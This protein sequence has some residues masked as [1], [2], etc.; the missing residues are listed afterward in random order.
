MYAEIWWLQMMT[1]KHGFSVK[2][3]FRWRQPN[4]VLILKIYS[5]K[6]H[7]HGFSF[8]KGFTKIWCTPNFPLPCYFIKFMET[9]LMFIK[10]YFLHSMDFT[11]LHWT[12]L[13]CTALY[14][15]E[16]HYTCLLTTVLCTGEHGSTDQLRDLPCYKPGQPSHTRQQ[17]Y[18]AD[19]VYW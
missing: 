5:E 1:T 7:D 19:I 9:Y 14:S 18:M 6:Y 10:G 2:S 12:V 17:V 8:K 11:E 4:M 13:F 3:G 16:L 15:T